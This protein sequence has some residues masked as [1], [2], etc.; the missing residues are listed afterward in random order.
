MNW[1]DITIEQLQELASIEHFEG[2]ERRIH[3]IA[4]VN[5]LDIDEVE[6]MTLEE[7]LNQVE[8]LK[9]LNELPQQKVKLS[10][11]HHKKRYKLIT[12]AQEMNAS[13]FVALQQI[14]SEAIIENLHRIIAML[15]YEVDLFGRRIEIP[16]GQVATNFEERCE[17]FKTLSCL[18]AYSYAVFFLAL[19]P[20]LLSVTLDFLKQEMSNLSA[21]R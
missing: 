21:E 1:K 18:N 13:H 3:Q 5:H 12:N 9:F 15:S 6:E 17:S 7:I 4:I 10:F 16:K 2:V 19:Y 11:R 8:K 14:N 20:Q